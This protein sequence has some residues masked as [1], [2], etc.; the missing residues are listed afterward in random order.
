MP[1]FHRFRHICSSCRSDTV[2]RNQKPSAS[3]QISAVWQRK[4]PRYYCF[5]LLYR[6]SKCHA[7]LFEPPPLWEHRLVLT[8]SKC[9]PRS[10]RSD[11]RGAE[12]NTLIAND[13]SR[14]M[15]V[16]HQGIHFKMRTPLKIDQLRPAGKRAAFAT[17]HPFCTGQGP[18]TQ[19]VPIRFE[20]RAGR[21]LRAPIPV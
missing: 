8:F 19:G 5:R 4:Y 12:P 6:I 1:R 17:C 11:G 10:G 2:A 15:L 21:A 9:E 18:C 13:V 16:G 14:M 20:P 7:L 3:G